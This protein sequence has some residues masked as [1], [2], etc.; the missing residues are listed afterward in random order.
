[1]KKNNSIKLNINLIIRIIEKNLQIKNSKKKKPKL[2]QFYLLGF[3]YFDNHL[4]FII[5][6]IKEHKI[7]NEPIL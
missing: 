5:N 6:N 4:F 3:I 2:F 1:M 7:I